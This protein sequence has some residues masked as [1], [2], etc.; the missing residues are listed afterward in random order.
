MENEQWIY[1]LFL[2]Y[3]CH[4]AATPT[5]HDLGVGAVALA[6]STAFYMPKATTLSE[7]TWVPEAEP[8]EHFLPVPVIP[9]ICCVWLLSSI[10][11]HHSSQFDAVLLR[12]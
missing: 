8:Q 7:L 2:L 5:K 1:Q 3:N 4:P 9:V 11:Q 12:A 6:L 10:T